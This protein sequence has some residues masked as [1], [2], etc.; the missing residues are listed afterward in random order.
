MST[1]FIAGAAEVLEGQ[2]L[3]F[4]II[5]ALSEGTSYRM[6]NLYETKDTVVGQN[7]QLMIMELRSLADHLESKGDL[8]E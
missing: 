2:G 7:R 6:Y 3:P 1:D 8:D 5:S 4:V